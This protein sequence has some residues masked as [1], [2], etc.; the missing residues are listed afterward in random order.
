MS[1]NTFKGPVSV[2]TCGHTGDMSTLSVK[3]MDDNTSE[4]AGLFGHGHCKVPKCPCNKFTWG[5]HRKEFLETL[6]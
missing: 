2:C 6:K 5:G 4:H 1:E 3:S